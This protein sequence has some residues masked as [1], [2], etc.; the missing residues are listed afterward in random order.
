MKTDYASFPHEPGRGFMHSIKDK[1]SLGT[2]FF[3]L[4]AVAFGMTLQ[5]H[6]DMIRYAL[7]NKIE[8]AKNLSIP[9]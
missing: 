5:L 7:N 3:E 1:T 8:A 4:I 6:D 2:S 9:G